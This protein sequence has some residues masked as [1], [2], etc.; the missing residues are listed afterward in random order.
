M[1]AIVAELVICL[2]GGA[3][4]T[5]F[6]PHSPATWAMVVWAFFLVQSLYFIFLGEVPEKKGDETPRDPFEEMSRR[7]ERIM[8]SDG[9]YEI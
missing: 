9:Y 1:K 3:L 5:Y 4:V 8:S 6:T 2:S 7:A